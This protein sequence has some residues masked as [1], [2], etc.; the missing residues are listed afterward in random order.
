M[1]RAAAETRK[2][3]IKRYAVELERSNRELQDFAYVA[4]HDLQ[5]PLRKITMFTDLVIEEN[6]NKLDEESISYLK[7]AQQ[8]AVRM[9]DL[10]KDLLSF[11]RVSTLEQPSEPVSLDRVVAEVLADLDLMIDEHGARVH[12]DSMPGIEADVA[13][14]RQLFQNL[15]VNAVKFRKENRSEE[16]RVG[17]E[18]RSRW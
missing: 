18:C 4:S 6:G 11:S 3:E 8:A 9:S 16:R 17:K 7:R 1:A 13:Q 2:D 15:L 12:V 14:M 5:E 10:I